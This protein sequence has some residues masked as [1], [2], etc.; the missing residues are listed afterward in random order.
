MRPLC[1]AARNLHFSLSARVPLPRGYLFDRRI[2]TKFAVFLF[3]VQGE[4]LRWWGDEH[5]QEPH[6]L[7]LTHSVS[8]SF[9]LRSTFAC[10]RPTP[11]CVCVLRSSRLT[12]FKISYEFQ[13][14]VTTANYRFVPIFFTYPSENRHVSRID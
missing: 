13:P 9:L 5:P 12:N 14:L 3:P 6:S 11:R 10:Q 1:T 7:L 4:S 8:L 2:R